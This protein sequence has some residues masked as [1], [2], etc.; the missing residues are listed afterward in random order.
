MGWLQWLQS[1]IVAVVSAFG[2]WLAIDAVATHLST[3]LTIGSIIRTAWNWIR[4]KRPDSDKSQRTSLRQSEEIHNSDSTL[5]D[6]PQ[7][8]GD[9]N[10]VIGTTKGKSQVHVGDSITHDQRTIVN[11][12][13]VN[14]WTFVTNMFG[15]YRKRSVSQESPKS[16]KRRVT[17]IDV[18]PPDTQPAGNEDAQ[19]RADIS[20]PPTP[21]EQ[22]APAQEYESDHD[23]V[24]HPA[25]PGPPL[26]TAIV[27]ILTP[28]EAQ[29]QSSS[30]SE[31]TNPSSTSAA[32][33]SAKPAGDIAR[34]EPTMPLGAD[35]THSTDRVIDADLSRSIE[36]I[37]TL[38]EA[39]EQSSMEMAA[40]FIRDKA[41]PIDQL[42]TETLN[43]DS[44]QNTNL[45][46]AASLAEVIPATELTT[47]AYEPGPPVSDDP[48]LDGDLST[49]PTAETTVAKADTVDRDIADIADNWPAL[50]ISATLK[51]L[52]QARGILSTDLSYDAGWA[53]NFEAGRWHTFQ[54]DRRRYIRGIRTYLQVLGMTPAE[55][56]ACLL[57]HTG[58]G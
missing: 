15:N 48:V 38:N 49:L 44:Q 20:S 51:R 1:P 21:N 23:E 18:S 17:G 53:I 26:P 37:D 54:T 30:E 29:R 35:N 55:L 50:T 16:P 28:L 12:R 40:T 19:P 3:V 27:P 34:I 47:H 13:F 5:T 32:D 56:Q 11:E 41:S 57:Q 42:A 25:E 52:R 2:G 33:G 39:S 7:V 45:G 31:N 58:Q 43:P 9:H 4:G 10:V 24:V 22:Y 8:R 36:A 6:S 14:T 46:A